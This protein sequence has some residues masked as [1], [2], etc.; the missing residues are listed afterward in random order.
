MFGFSARSWC[1]ALCLIAVAALL[2]QAPGPDAR[3]AA[4]TTGWIVRLAAGAVLGEEVAANARQGV[5]VSRTFSRALKGLVVNASAAQAE[6]IRRR[7]GVLSVEPD[8][9]VRAADTQ[10]SPPWGLDRLDQRA[11][12]LSTTYSWG[13]NGS[14]VKAYIVDSG[15]RRTHSQFTGR[16]ATGTTFITD[17][18]GTEDCS[19]HGTHVSGTVA[20]TTYGVAKAAT[21]VPVRVF[22]CGTS[23]LLSG[24]ISA[25]D[26]IVTDHAAGTPAVANLS[27]EASTS[28][29]LDA[30]IQSTINDGVTVVV[31]AGNGATSACSVSPARAANAIT[32]AAT[33]IN[34]VQASFSNFG[35]CVDLY[36][37]GVNI[38]SA[39]YTGDNDGVFISG[40]SMASPHV[41]GV[42][43]VLLS[44]T[45]SL[46]PAA[47]TSAIVSAATTG[48][49]TS[50][51]TGSP[52]R[53]L[54]KNSTVSLTGTVT[55]STGQVVQGVTVSTAAGGV[56]IAS[57]M[58]SPTGTYTL[59]V[60]TGSI[61][62]TVE[63]G[64]SA[65]TN[66]PLGWRFTGIP[67]TLSTS[68][69]Q[70]FQLPAAT[71]LRM[72]V[73]GSD[74][75]AVSGVQIYSG[76]AYNATPISLGAG[77]TATAPTTTLSPAVTDTAGL[78]TLYGF[79]GTVST[80]YADQGSGAS[81]VRATAQSVPLTPNGPIVTI[82]RGGTTTAT[83][84]YLLGDKGF[85]P[86]MSA[87][88]GQA[89]GMTPVGGADDSAY[90]CTTYS[91][92]DDT[93]AA[94]LL[95]GLT[96]LDTGGVSRPAADP[97]CLPLAIVGR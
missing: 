79:P 84:T 88:I 51:G 65:L 93:E 86:L 75:R 14:G 8:V 44:E 92:R 6:A 54:Y 22:D 89:I 36:A 59:D 2:G 91:P 23:G 20:G 56:P 53:L 63:S 60:P 1:A 31:A 39:W 74:G 45:P 57:T 26:W 94:N 18:R 11:L 96:Y 33:D 46:T 68:G 7:P 42:A 19:G 67:L 81:L 85:S 28:S 40:T 9:I 38:A 95:R 66:Y 16:V 69:S 24:V 82:A 78:A 13:G 17:G 35:S 27:L 4:P 58:T 62:V 3:A 50:L 97:D 21:V 80:I 41:A 70:N 76:A 12:P 71:A 29:A 37:P 83:P 49:V 55:D 77:L 5:G 52:N 73:Y 10:S 64:S 47:V 48:A 61:S 87:L 34:D 90:G 72:R 25:L 15:I 30:A 32:V 43:A